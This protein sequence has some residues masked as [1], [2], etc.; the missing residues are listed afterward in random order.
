MSNIQKITLC[1]M[2][3]VCV[4]LTGFV[5]AADFPGWGE[6]PYLRRGGGQ[7][8]YMP[9]QAYFNTT[10]TRRVAHFIGADDNFLTVADSASDSTS[11]ISSLSA[12]SDGITDTR[13]G[14]VPSATA[15]E[16]IQTNF[17]N[18][19]YDTVAQVIS[20]ETCISEAA[21]GR[22]TLT[23]MTRPTAL[24]SPRGPNRHELT[25]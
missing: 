21:S 2:L 6:W 14:M 4:V 20:T 17:F 18:V 8:S 25:A 22:A 1:A 9:G 19:Y 13:F 12:S 7:T 10:Q 5:S 23:F 16:T 3:F 15:S 24:R 11:T